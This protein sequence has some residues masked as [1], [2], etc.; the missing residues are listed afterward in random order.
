MK[1]FFNSDICSQVAAWE[2]L[3]DDK[4]HP[5]FFNDIQDPEFDDTLFGEIRLT[6]KTVLSAVQQCMGVPIVEHLLFTQLVAEKELSQAEIQKR[7]G[8]DG[9]VVTRL[10]KQLE[11]KGLVVR[12]PD[13]TDNRFTLVALTEK[14]YKFAEEKIER[15]R[16]LMTILMNGISTE[17]VECLKHVLAQVRQNAQDLP[18]SGEF[19]KE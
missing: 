10:V 8:V 13:P 7:L 1:C 5:I 17:D 6:V 18:S 9:A 12:R 16:K 14:A 19:L 11:S 3:M 2:L 15:R 4:I